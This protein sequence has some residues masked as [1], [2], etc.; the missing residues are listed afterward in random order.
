VAA[1]CSLFWFESEISPKK[2]TLLLVPSC[3]HYGEVVERLESGSQW[4]EA[5]SLQRVLEGDIVR[6]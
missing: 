2:L 3:W 6:T 4:K 1:L 5:G